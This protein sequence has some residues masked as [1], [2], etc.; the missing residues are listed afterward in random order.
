MIERNKGREQPRGDI[1]KTGVRYLQ[2][3]ERQRPPEAGGGKEEFSTRAVR[4]R[5]SCD[6]LISDFQPPEL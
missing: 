4:G 5:W 6:T 2:G 1:D 3:K